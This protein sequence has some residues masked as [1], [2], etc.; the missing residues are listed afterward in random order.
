MNKDTQK[1]QIQLILGQRSTKE[2]DAFY[3]YQ[4][5]ESCHFEVWHQWALGL[6]A[7]LPPGSLD[8][9]YNKRIDYLLAEC[10][11]RFKLTSDRSHT[12]SDN[13]IRAVIRD[14]TP[15]SFSER[16]ELQIPTKF[17]QYLPKEK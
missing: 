1:R 14:I 10:R 7:N 3:I 4:L 5:I 9:D 13:M 12:G 16:L 17:T 6:A 15:N 11:K 8:H 2:P